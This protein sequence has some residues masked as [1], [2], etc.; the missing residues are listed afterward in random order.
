MTT[1]NNAQIM[2]I[3]DKI[4]QYLAQHPDATDTPPGIARG[5]VAG[6][7]DELSPM[8][9]EAALALLVSRGV[10]ESRQTPEGQVLYSR[11]LHGE[12]DKAQ[13]R[14]MTAQLAQWRTQVV[15]THQ[16]LGWKIGFND[17]A[18]QE[19]MGL[20][21]PVIGYLRRGAL[22]ATGDRFLAPPGATIKIE[23][24]IALRIGRDVAADATVEASEAA[25]AAMATAF[26][27]VD[28]TQRL[29]GLEALLRGNLYHAAV[30]LGPEVSLVPKD[31]RREIS[32][33][34][35]T[36]S[37]VVRTVEPQRLPARFGEFVQVVAATLGRHGER[38]CAGDWIICGSTIEPVTVATGDHVKGEIASLAPIELMIEKPG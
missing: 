7:K 22:L 21:A 9:V 27:V 3:A 10:V 28:V 23:M 26:E 14:G 20:C 13:T 17:R 38:L 34:L 30:L 37:G 18:S 29:E 6:R 35:Q 19:R 2:N 25:I 1:D 8:L 32:G 31:P 36:T 16:R 33:R 5:W 24:E 12:T 11:A 15:A 4:A